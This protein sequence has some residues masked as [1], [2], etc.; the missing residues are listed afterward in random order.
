MH[1]SLGSV[2]SKWCNHPHKLQENRVIVGFS[3]YYPYLNY[4]LIQI[5]FVYSYTTQINGS[6]FISC[7]E[8]LYIKNNYFLYIAIIQM[9]WQFSFIR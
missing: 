5:I 6:Y 2:F 7:N 8:R 9:M 4:T 1:I 3:S